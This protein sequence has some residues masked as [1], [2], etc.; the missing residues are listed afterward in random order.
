MKIE[1]YTMTNEE[2]AG[3]L[4]SA[5]AVAASEMV[6]DGLIETPEQVTDRYL[7]VVPRKGRFARMFERLYD[8]KDEEGTAKITVVRVDSSAKEVQ[9]K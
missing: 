3:Y 8:A 5:I 6:K 2:L 4:N 7:A 9:T 1:T